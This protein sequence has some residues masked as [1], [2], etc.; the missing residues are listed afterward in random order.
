MVRSKEEVVRLHEKTVQPSHKTSLLGSK[1]NYVPPQLLARG[2]GQRLADMYTFKKQATTG[3]LI[4]I[5]VGAKTSAG[6]G[7]EVL[8][9]IQGQKNNSK[10]LLT[11]DDFDVN[12]DGASFDPLFT[13]PSATRNNIEG[14]ELSPEPVHEEN[15]DDELSSEDEDMHIQNGNENFDNHDNEACEDILE[16][17]HVDEIEISQTIQDVNGGGSSFAEKNV[18]QKKKGRN[19]CKE[20]AKLK[21]DEKLEITFY[22]NRVVVTNHKVFVRHLGIIVRD[23]NICPVKVRKWDDIGDKEKEHMWSAVT[24]AFTN[25]SM[26]IYTQHVL[27][28]MRELWTNWRSDLLRNNVTKKGI[29]LE[30]AYKGEPPSGLDGKDWKWLIKEVYSDEKFKEKS[31]RNSENRRS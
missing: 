27:G 17:V 16:N 5:G 30:A 9:P 8:K 25:E 24:D 4:G 1:R 6:V 2:R 13:Y 21:P 12:V 28:H 18:N 10:G 29:T 15:M 26:D 14:W 3:S 7:S 31:A 20:I 11:G 19:K 23:T 22:N